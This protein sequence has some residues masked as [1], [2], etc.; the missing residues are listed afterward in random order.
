MKVEAE[1]SSEEEVDPDEARQVH[2]TNEIKK[3]LTSILIQVTDSMFGEFLEPIL[4]SALLGHAHLFMTRRIKL[5]RKMTLLP[6][7]E[8]KA[9]CASSVQHSSCL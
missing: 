7:I 4:A 8:G 2:L 5:A 3:S 9:N 6:G 1:D